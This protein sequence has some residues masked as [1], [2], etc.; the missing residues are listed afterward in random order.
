MPKRLSRW[1]RAA[2]AHLLGENQVVSDI[3]AFC[4]P[5]IVTDAEIDDMFDRLAPALA[6]LSQT[7]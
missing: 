1:R 3:I 6:R 4:P 5:L 7:P 2:A